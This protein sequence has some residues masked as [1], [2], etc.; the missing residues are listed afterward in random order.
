[1]SFLFLLRQIIIDLKHVLQMRTSYILRLPSIPFRCAAIGASNLAREW[2]SGK[3]GINNLPDAILKKNSVCTNMSMCRA[4]P[5]K[6]VILPVYT[7]T[8][9]PR[10]LRSDGIVTTER[11]LRMPFVID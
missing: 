10:P 5:F 11:L 2:H 7:L 4:G 8:L 1:M 9:L 6:R 3:V